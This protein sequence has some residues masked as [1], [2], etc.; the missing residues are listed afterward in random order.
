MERHED[1][2]RGNPMLKEHDRYSLACLV[3][4]VVQDC[5]LAKNLVDDSIDLQTLAEDN[6]LYEA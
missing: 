3:G 2:K 5:A 1:A 4:N 6:S